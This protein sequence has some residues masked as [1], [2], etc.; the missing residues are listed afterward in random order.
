MVSLA[1]RPGS[2]YEIGQQFARSIGHFWSATHQQIYRTLK[3]LSDDNLVTFE[4]ISQDGRPDKKVYTLSEQ[5][6]DA[7]MDWIAQPTPITA[8][9]DE[10]AVKLRMAHLNPRAIIDELERLVAERQEQLA[11]YKQF[12]RADYPDPTELTGPRL[13]RYLVLLGGIRSQEFYIDWANEVLSALK[14]DSL[15]IAI[16]S[17]S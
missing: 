5:G 10:F 1:E 11:L 17:K 7:L 9:R 6:R 8:L 3:R 4:S 2:G 14:S 12:E 15:A 16:E 13:H